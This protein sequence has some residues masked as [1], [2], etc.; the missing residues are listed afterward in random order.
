[1]NR[2]CTSLSGRLF[3]SDVFGIFQCAKLVIYYPENW[4]KRIKIFPKFTG[5]PSQ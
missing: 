5:S 3:R 4:K 1:M 2:L